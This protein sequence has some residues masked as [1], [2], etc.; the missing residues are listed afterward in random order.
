MRRLIVWAL[1]GAG[2]LL[3]RLP[4]YPYFLYRWFM[5]TSSDLQVGDN[6]P[7]GP[8]A[9][10]QIAPIGDGRDMKGFDVAMPVGER[11]AERERLSVEPGPVSPVDDSRNCRSGDAAVRSH[12]RLQ[13]APRYPAPDLAHLLFIEFAEVLFGAS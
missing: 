9:S 12:A 1:F 3:S 11:A 8:H 6:G 5:A 7:W 4:W 2:H 13:L 10:A